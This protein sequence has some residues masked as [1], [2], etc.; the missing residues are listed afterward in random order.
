MA[1]T[2]E[3]LWHHPI[4]R[5]PEV[6]ALLAQGFLASA[7]EQ[8]QKE[9]GT[10]SFHYKEVNLLVPAAVQAGQVSV[11]QDSDSVTADATA[12]AAL[13]AVPTAFPVI[14][15]QFKAGTQ[16]PFYDITA[17]SSPTITLD[18]DYYEETNST[19]AYSAMKAYEL[20]PDDFDRW[21]SVVDLV[22][23]FQIDVYQTRQELDQRDPQ[24]SITDSPRALVAFDYVR[25]TG[26]VRFEWYPFPQER[27]QYPAL[28]TTIP[29]VLSATQ[30]LPANIPQRVIEL[31][32][33]LQ[34]FEW[35][36][37]NRG[38]FKTLQGADWRFLHD[39]MMK[40]YEEELVDV[41]REDQD[42]FHS[43]FGT[44][45]LNPP[46]YG[47]GARYLQS[48]APYPAASR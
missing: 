40:K 47:R 27:R 1:G 32:V 18:R 48:H 3:A 25:S 41:K 31:A 4:G 24:R 7:W 28:Y 38:R 10:W 17:Y 2:F 19:S 22:E 6:N 11:T 8:F 13:D 9:K 45:Y 39:R 20:A 46:L 29:W 43:N 5:V 44:N 21:E 33:M 14:G 12:A 35:A 16:G 15:R 23:D 37:A 30:P 26:R 36:E 34:A 42:I